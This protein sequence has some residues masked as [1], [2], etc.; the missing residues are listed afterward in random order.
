MHLRM[1]VSG[2][3]LALFGNNPD[4]TKQKRGGG[5]NVRIEL[6]DGKVKFKP[7]SRPAKPVGKPYDT[8]EMF[9]KSID[10][11]SGLTEPFV[12]LDGMAAG[13]FII[14]KPNRGWQELAADTNGPIE[15]IEV[16]PPA[17]VVKAAKAAEAKP[18]EKA[19]EAGKDAKKDKK[20][21]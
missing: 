9:G 14:S 21:S 16:P 15:F 4:L 8:I 12:A 2:E 17:P 11:E 7:T 19:A 3:A 10:H 18:A 5:E 13:R 20:K 1:R 6:K